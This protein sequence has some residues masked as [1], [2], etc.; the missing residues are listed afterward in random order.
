MRSTLPAANH[1]ELISLPIYTTSGEA[2]P[3]KKP[4]TYNFHPEW[5]EDFFFAMSFTVRLS[6]LQLYDCYFEEG[7]YGAALSDSSQDERH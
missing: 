6:D 4:K 5:E 1:R 3:S 2:G 7:K